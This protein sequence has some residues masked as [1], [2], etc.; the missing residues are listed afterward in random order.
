MHIDIDKIKR[1]IDKGVKMGLKFVEVRV[2]SIST[3]YI[4]YENNR[5]TGAGIDRSIGVGIRVMYN[6]KIGFAAS[7]D[8]KEDNIIDTLNSSIKSARAANMES[9]LY[10]NEVYTD[11]IEPPDVRLHPSEVD[12]PEK[13]QDIKDLH[14]HMLDIK[15]AVK[16]SEFAPSDISIKNTT[17]RYVSV[18]GDLLILNSEGLSV[19]FKPLITGYLSLVVAERRGVLGDGTMILGGSMGYDVLRKELFERAYEATLKAAEKTVAKPPP[20]GE[21]LVISYPEVT[22]LFAHESF[23]HMSEG[24][25]VL[26]GSSPLKDLV[27]EKVASEVVS[28]VDDGVPQYKP[29]VYL[30]VD[31]EGVRSKK[32]FLVK[33]GVDVG[34]LHCRLTA[35]EMDVESTGNGRAQS[36]RFAPIVRM[37]NT[38][39][40]AG[41]WEE[42][43]IISEFRK[44]IIV[45]DGR[46]GQAELDGTFTFSASRGYLVE[47]GEKV[48]PIRDVLLS[49]NILTM[50]KKVVAAGKDV[51]IESAPFGACGKGGQGVYV[52]LG[53]PI[54]VIERMNIG[55]RV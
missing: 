33:N 7:D 8:L 24:D 5:V 6:G 3:E 36:H 52:G 13:L 29:H 15:T 26:S 9:K 46:G 14:R 4:T 28:I 10:L 53:G 40:D 23:G 54:L 22:G 2:E 38:F 55:G 47:R 37:R 20:P 31:S 48:A 19:E 51:Y 43:E 42:D 44:G 41:D 49:G 1:I 35:G 30:P 18:Y 12:F 11:K 50:L 17:I 45:M 32:V 16:M 39:F 21:W 34:F 27:N 25:F